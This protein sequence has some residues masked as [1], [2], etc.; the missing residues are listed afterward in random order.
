MHA[1]DI[2]GLMAVG[3][4]T[5][6]V[7]APAVL[8]PARWAEL[9]LEHGITVWHSVPALLEM[10]VDH[11]EPHPELHAESLRLVLLGGD[12][13][14]VNLPDRLK[15][16]VDG[17]HVVSM[18]GATECS[19]DST[20]YDIESPSSNW[21]SI[22]Y[23]VPMANQLAYILDRHFNPVPVGV[24]G[25]LYLGGIGVGRG[26][27]NRPELTAEKFV[28]NPFSE[29]AG[30]RMY[31]TG[32]LARYMPDGTLELLGRIDFQVKVRG[33]RVELGEITSTLTQHP[34][35]KEAV[36]V[37]QDIEKGNPARGKQLV[38][39]IV[40]DLQYDG[41]AESTSDDW[42]TEQVS[43][44]QTIYEETY[45]QSDADKDPTFNIIGWN[46]SYT[47]L[48]IP[49]QEMAE[50]LQQ[51]VDRVLTLE[52]K[53]VLEI[54][55]GSG[56]LLFKIAPHCEAY[57]GT[58]FSAAGL[59]YI[60][61]Q[62]KAPER[63]MPHVSL[64]QRMADNFEGMTPNSFDAA[65]LHSV[66]QLFPSLEY[67][68]RVLKNLVNTVEPG[69]FI[70]VGDV[71]SLSLMEA[72]HTSVQLYQAPARLSTDEL[73]ERIKKARLQEEQLFIDPEFFHAFKQDFP[74]I[75]RVQIQ[76]RRGRALNEMT[77]FRYDVILQIGEG[78][79]N[80]SVHHIYWMDWRQEG[81]SVTQVREILT[82]DK[83]EL[84]ALRNVPNARLKKEMKALELLNDR[85]APK[86]VGELRSQVN[87]I[88]GEGFVDPEEL[89]SLGDD[90]PYDVII[91]WS[92]ELSG[93]FDVILRQKSQDSPAPAFFFEE[94][95]I[96]AKAWR[97]YAN[98]PLQ[99]VLARRLIPGVRNY[100]QEHLPDYMVPYSFMLLDALPLSPNGKIDRRALPPP[101]HSRP[102]LTSN[103]VAPRN[104][105]EELVT[106]VW[107][108]IFELEKVG[109]QDN[110]LEMGGHSLL[111][112]QI[113]ARLQEVFPLQLP[114][115]YLFGSPTVAGL[116]ERIQE[117]GQ[118]EG[119]DVMEI[120]RAVLTVNQLSD[121]EVRS[122]L[123]EKEQQA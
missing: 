5:V 61:E 24:P 121:E 12:W 106:A 90:L 14:P 97:E 108:E 104:P 112:T 72:F 6:I 73:R 9:M 111:A 50:W 76:L 79:T 78:A 57:H 21:K 77:Q 1:Y 41:K 86:T 40:P 95:E 110:F 10:Y 60:R 99:S 47:G 28:P 75:T 39:Y 81:L 93:Y 118:E 88:S 18:G 92:E 43:Q 117:K 109:V 29:V 100:L 46:S 65:I 23:G 115:R 64:E 56:L 2:F 68:M 63:Q 116:S 114:L 7:E 53:R 67:F 59:N 113:M 74:A 16:I 20:I 54:A 22:P 26:Y 101:D 30:D 4:T 17:V 96:R 45:S 38:G 103:F 102:Q 52:P 89:W 44:W 33:Y 55:C 62:L 94:R 25:E 91:N 13:I 42:Q 3:G 49:E 37:A 34:G 31:R 51:S 119:I 82:D 98:N 27:H 123:A 58:D 80:G 32:D 70:Y 19:M 36:V 84:L 66:V 87:A 8:E 120:A 11:I 105:L 15:A 83:P 35:V 71:I 69:G 122:M 48:P 107:A 85:H